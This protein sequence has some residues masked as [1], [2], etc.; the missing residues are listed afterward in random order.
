MTEMNIPL[1]ITY[2]TKGTTPI[3][4]VIEALRSTDALA[5]DAVSLLPSIF[6]GMRIEES[7]LNVRSI[8]QES[9]L[10]ELFFVT[11]F[12]TFQSSL[13]TEVPPMLEELFG[14]RV[15]DRYDSIVT[16]L[17]MIVVFYGVNFAVDA[18]KNTIAD[19]RARKTL[20][21]LLKT[22]AAETGKSEED[23]R[24]ILDSHFNEPKPFKRLIR[25]ATSFFL[26][27]QQDGNAPVTVDRS[28]IDSDTVREVP[29]RSNTS[30]P[31][32]F[33][34][35]EPHSDVELHLHASDRDKSATGWA[36]VAVG[37]CDRRLKLKLVNGI[38]PGAL[39]GKDV[40]RGNIM[41]IKKLTADGYQPSEIH[42]S[43]LVG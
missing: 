5:R 33:D 36:A 39:W 4:D 6:E 24:A 9:P 19:H 30:K 22:A 43:E 41:L 35:H 16:V 38:E 34:R 7:S 11:L 21:A 26:P 15:D 2:Q 10:R 40:V 29:Y 3:A 32:E 28:E 14:V 42:L 17:F 12:V 31:S 27:S 20:N 1:S 23:L 18:A 25:N 8:S 37:L 13:T